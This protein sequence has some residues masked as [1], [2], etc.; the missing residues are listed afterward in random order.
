[1]EY[2]GPRVIE[3]SVGI[4]YTLELDKPTHTVTLVYKGKRQRA[5]IFDMM[6]KALD[7]YARIKQVKDIKEIDNL[8]DQYR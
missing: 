3:K 2:I 8:Y 1:M 4:K 7:F 6:Y 5:Y